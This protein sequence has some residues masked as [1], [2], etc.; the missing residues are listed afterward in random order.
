MSSDVRHKLVG[1]LDYVEQVARI[2]ERVAF[3]LQ[4]YVLPDGSRF[5]ARD[6]ELRD[7]PG[8]S[9]DSSDGVGAIWIEVAREAG[10][11]HRTLDALHQ[12]REAG[13]DRI[14]LIVGIGT[15]RWQKNGAALE[16]PLLE[17]RV[18]IER[19]AA[20]HALRVR[21]TQADALFD[22]RPYERLGCTK[23]ATLSNLIRREIARAAK[24]DGISPF[25]P[26]SA[27]PILTAAA[28]RLD[29]KG[30]YRPGPDAPSIV[31]DDAEHLTI[32]AGWVLFARA[33][34]QLATLND[35]DRLRDAALDETQPLSGLAEKLIAT[36]SFRMESSFHA[37]P[38]APAA[39][40][41]W[42]SESGGEDDDDW[43]EEE[44]MRLAAPAPLPAAEP[45]A[46]SGAPAGSDV[47]DVFF[48][49]PHNDAQ[50][51]I[52]RR[53]EAAEGGLAVQAPPGTGATH[54]IANLVSHALASGQRVLVTAHREAVL[55]GLRDQL[56]AEIRA[57]SVALTAN[58]AEGLRQIEAAIREV[59]SDDE[60][61]LPGKRRAAIARLELQMSQHRERIVTIDRELSEIAAANAA[62]IGARRETPVEL[63]LRL[64]AEPDADEGFTD[65]PLR[66]AADAGF[67][68]AELAALEAARR[69]AGELLEHRGANLPFAADL[70]DADKVALW[71]NA[72]IAA[73]R[74]DDEATKGPA[75]SLD[76][77]QDNV[78]QA[79]LLAQALDDFAWT[80][81]I[82]IDE[83]WIAR[84]R[85][86][87]LTGEPDAAGRKLKEIAA[88]FDA[89]DRRR[90]TL[91][92]RAI[93]LP[94]SLA[95]ERERD[96]A[97]RWSEVLKEIG[98]LADGREKETLDL[99]RKLIHACEKVPQL[100]A[101]LAAVTA[102]T[103]TFDALAK[104]RALCGALARQLRIAAD[105]INLA[106]VDQDRRRLMTL[107]RD[108]GRMSVLVRQ[109]I[110]EA[111]GDADIPEARIKLLWSGVL[112]RLDEIKALTE[113]F[114]TIEAVTGAIALAGAPDWANRLATEK[115]ADGD[116]VLPQ[117]WRA[118]WRD[119][120]DRAAAQGH[121]D[122]ID[123]QGRISQLA[124]DRAD[125]E[126]QC[127]E[128]FGALIR[129]RTF[130]QIGLKLTAESKTALEAC[131]RALDRAAA[132]K[133]TAAQ[134]RKARDAMAKC[135]DA[136]ACWIVPAWR[137]AEEIP[138]ELGA[139]D[140]VI[141]DD[142]S[143]SGVGEL[144]VLL[145]G[146]KVLA[147]GDSRQTGPRAPFATQEEIGKLRERF[148]GEMPASFKRHLEPG[149]NLFA[150]MQAVFPDE[151]PALTENFRSVEPIVRFSS[152]FYPEGLVP[153]RI[154]AARDRLD[155]A[156]IDIH[157]TNGVRDRVRR[158]NAAEADIIVSDIEDMVT[159]PEMEGRSI[160]VISLAGEAQA[161]YI[162]KRL[163]GAIGED[164]MRRHSILCG[165]PALFQG[166]SRDI[167]YL[168]M[169]TGPADAAAMTMAHYEQRF[170]VAVSAA[171][172]RLVL[173]R[174]VRR[175]D[176]EAD[177]LRARLIDHFEN[178]MGDAVMPSDALAACETDF[179][180]ELMEELLKRGYRVQSQAGAQGHRIDLVVEGGNGARLAIACD[181]DRDGAG[182]WAEDMRRQRALERAG[183][184][185]WRGFALSFARN[186][187][188][189]MADLVATLSRLGIEPQ[190]DGE[191]APRPGVMTEQRTA[192]AATRP[193][194]ISI[195]PDVDDA[196]S[197][198][199][200]TATS[201]LD[202]G[203]RAVLQ[204]S[205]DRMRISVAI[206]EAADDLTA[207]RL[208]ARSA[209]GRALLGA[210]E[211]DEIE[212]DE[213]DER[214]QPRRVLVEHI[215][216]GEPQA[217]ARMLA[218]A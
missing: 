129:E 115:A 16:R 12:Q 112:K 21:P 201:G 149:E 147:L 84:F 46:D 202:I 60:G 150:L 175:D 8:V 76:V 34:S 81:Q 19:D 152:Q 193:S 55:T 146:K 200:E 57:L 172:D 6:G 159:R 192:E 66:F 145:R 209:L 86:G 123:V 89:I 190:R 22:L 91:R 161:Q 158:I 109:F 157:V 177:D 194:D 134:K 203:D 43:D 124:Q 69:K 206:T 93:E 170:N 133:A 64:A 17:R 27:A 83:P 100:K 184:T 187:E 54:T 61:T 167:V 131:V 4:D 5:S 102:G 96:L 71:H 92:G 10:A 7:A 179:E 171:K 2:D 213:D 85:D 28:T 128:I 173:V 98:A 20:T 31:P 26:D 68:D 108:G 44:F 215:E 104:D 120:W 53:L 185:F 25:A 138:A 15:V 197:L 169:V 101:L 52:C 65:R 163:E 33:R 208:S 117:D 164:A 178:P 14:E 214:G 29:P 47:P 151:T 41:D 132:P 156:L 88:A 168:S 189:V 182:I 176:L 137:V 188:A 118:T 142:A 56:P 42:G 199:D 105:S 74:S 136:V 94:T 165:E 70:P 37:A 196:T 174:S 77:T 103:V 99:A 122:R 139:F 160:G 23:L 51:E 35:I 121:L 181:G 82:V 116:T 140:L 59:Q 38:V 95:D 153:L 11:L 50:A 39:P 111:V 198:R 211:G 110:G 125:A 155:P 217:A 204:V 144:P 62:R 40:I 80:Q 79:Q 186:P 207:G 205:G 166:V 130:Y 32:T 143:Q 191:T 148:L 87:A 183:W 36:P 67:G 48:P 18:E 114:Q 75:T 141:L 180:R 63:A 3:G 212:L 154:P 58:E 78:A 210:E 9:L 13:D 90:A 1:L 49:K 119:I 106:S 218:S 135:R 73:K 97:A 127:Q 113:E 30:V 216:K 195:A 107:F 126:R 72:L 24:K 45:A 162:R